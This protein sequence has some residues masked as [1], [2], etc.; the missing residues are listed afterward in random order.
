VDDVPDFF[1][2][3]LWNYC[4]GSKTGDHTYKVENCTKPESKFAYNPLESWGLN[5]SDVDQLLP[6]QDSKALKTYQTATKWVFIGWM[7]AL[8]LTILELIIGFTSFCSPWGSAATGFISGCSSLFLMLAASGSTALAVAV[9]GIV[10]SNLTKYNVK[11][12]IGTQVLGFEWAAV[13]LSLAAG[14]FWFITSCCGSSHHNLRNRRSR[15]IDGGKRNSSH[16]SQYYSKNGNYEPVQS[17]YIPPGPQSYPG[18]QDPMMQQGTAYEP[19][20]H[21]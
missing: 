5:S 16:N 14:L 1:S 21:V 17:P 7:V 6:S 2:V 3:Y 13:A 9:V 19:Y 8:A 11:G 12:R 15:S 18:P 10:E 20:R 4:Y